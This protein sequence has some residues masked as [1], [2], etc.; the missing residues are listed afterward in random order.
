MAG[1]IQIPG[2]S[3]LRSCS[4]SVP[5]VEHHHHEDEQ[6][7]NGPGV[8]DDFQRSGEVR[9]QRE[10]HPGNRQQRNNQVQQRMHRIGVVTTRK[11]A[12]MAIRPQI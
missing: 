7:H 8:D 12:R 11:V 6:H 5:P 1:P 10:E 3:H 2:C 9:A 4:I